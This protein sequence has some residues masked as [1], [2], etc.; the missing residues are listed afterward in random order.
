M[1]CTGCAENFQAEN[2]VEH[3]IHNNN[4]RKIMREVN[5]VE[6]GIGLTRELNV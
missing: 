4:M 1:G 6:L 5:L 2:W 3:F